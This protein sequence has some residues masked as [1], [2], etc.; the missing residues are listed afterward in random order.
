MVLLDCQSVMFFR[1][2]V[3]CTWRIWLCF[4]RLFCTGDFSSKNLQSVIIC[5]WIFVGIFSRF[6]FKSLF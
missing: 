4:L 1:E 6:H 3:I 5:N 2:R